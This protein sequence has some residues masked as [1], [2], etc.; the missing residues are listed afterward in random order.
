MFPLKLAAEM[1]CGFLALAKLPYVKAEDNFRIKFAKSFGKDVDFNEKTVYKHQRIW[2]YA[3]TYAVTS[4]QD[5]I[6]TV[7]CL[8]K[9]VVKKVQP[10]I[11]SWKH[12]KVDNT[13]IINLWEIQ[14]E[15]SSH[16]KLSD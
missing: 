1:H 3:S 8:W 2:Q 4:L 6:D 16:D 9:T 12:F 13:R 11:P 10:L 15:N 5:A 7:G 14:A